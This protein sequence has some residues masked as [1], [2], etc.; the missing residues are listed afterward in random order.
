M[1]YNKIVLAGGTGYLGTVLAAYYQEFANEIIILSRRAAVL[2]GNTRIEIWDGKTEGQWVSSLEGADLL[3]NL[4]GK[5]INCRYNEK[6]RKEIIDSRIIPTT[7]LGKVISKLSTPPKLWINI[8]A[9]GIYKH[10]IDQWQDEETGE[11]G[12]G[13][14]YEVCKQWEDNFF[15]SDTPATRK[16]ALRMGV[17]LGRGDGAFPRLL[18]LVKY[19]M[20]G[21]QGSG[22][23][24]ISWIHE[25]DVARCSEWIMQYPELNGA[26]N[27]TAPEPVNNRTMMK[28]IRDAYGIPFGF[29]APAW[30]LEIGAAMIG[31]ETEL[32]LKSNR[33]V[34]T[35]LLS[36][37]FKF[38]FATAE[39]AIQNLIKK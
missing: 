38:Q 1:K 10:S 13:F 2:K 34:P 6:N 15:G 31:T 14:F 23:Q 27:C 36:S 17:V 21:K 19:G 16:I 12:D 35:R 33:V 24:Y 8:T 39:E 30:V 28:I 32:I 26:V 5:N 3:I 25:Q 9:A 7:L 37:G 20:G 18:N 22:D 4:C 11:M 29:P